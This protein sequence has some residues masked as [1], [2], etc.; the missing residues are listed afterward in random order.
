MSASPSPTTPTQD[1]ILTE[2]AVEWCVRVN[3]G[4]CT[5]QDLIALQRWLDADPRHAREFEAV[6][7]LWSISRELPAPEGLFAAQQP[8]RRVPAARRLLRLAAAASAASAAVWALGW[9]FAWLPSSYHRYSSAQLA[10]TVEMSDGTEVDLNV[11]SSLVYRN[12]RDARRVRLNDGEAFFRVAHDA[13]HPFVVEAGRGTITV[14]GTAFNVFKSGETVIVTLLEGSVEVQ[15]APA[16]GPA[17]ALRL[18]PMTQA[19]YSERGAPWQRPVQESEIAAWRH[20]KLVLNDTTLRDA[21]M[22]LNRYLPADEQYTSVDP[23]I[24][25]LRLGGTYDTRNAAE[26]AR[27]LPAI[28]PVRTQR[29]SDGGL[30][31]VPASPTP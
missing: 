22:Q 2:Q 4:A 3:D 16:G 23:S 31:L 7:Q 10:Q 13:A 24:G 30:M 8:A 28:L 11:N 27:A 21:V 25:G 19:R 9:S 5:E 17:K 12:Y 14:T 6:Q 26:L 29:G 1:D 15:A 20:G 18:Q